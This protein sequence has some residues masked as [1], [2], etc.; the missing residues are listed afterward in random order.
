MNDIEAYFLFSCEKGLKKRGKNGIKEYEERLKYETTIIRNMGYCGYF[1]VV[2]DM[3]DWALSQ[4]IPIGPGRGSAAGALVSYVLYIT[5]LDPIKYKLIFE[6]FL[7]PSRISMPDID[8]DLDE[9]RREEV[10]DYLKNKYGKDN[11]AHIGT[12]GKMKAKAAIRDVCRTLGFDYNVGDKLSRLTLD[13]IAGKSQPLIECYD[14]VPELKN[15]RYGED[16]PEKTILSWAEKIEDKEKSFGTHA[17]FAYSSQ[18][19]TTFGPKSIG[20]LCGETVEILTSRGLQKAKISY[21]G[22]KEIVDLLFTSCKSSHRYQKISLTPDHKIYTNNGWIETEKSINQQLGYIKW[23]DKHSFISLFAGWIWNDGCW[24]ESQ[25]REY[26]YFTPGDD[27][28]AKEYFL[29]ALCSQKFLNRLDKHVVKKAFIDQ[30][31]EKFGENFKCKLKDKDVPIFHNLSDK[32]GWLCGFISANGSIQRGE[33]RLKICSFK[34]LSFIKNEIESLGIF[35]SSIK[36]RK[37]QIVYIDNRKIINN[38]SYEICLSVSSSFFFLSLIG[39]IQKRKED[40]FKQHQVFYLRNCRIE[41][42]YDFSVLN[43]DPKNQNGYVNGLLVHNSGILISPTPIKEIVPLYP[44]LNG[45]A[46]TQY[47]MNIVDQVGLTKFDLLGLRAL[48][49]IDKCINLIYQRKNIRLNSLELPVDDKKTFKTLQR[50]D[51]VGLFQLESSGMRDLVVQIRP[52]KLED[53][54]VLVA[55]YRPGPLSSEGFKHYLE[56]RKGESSPHYLI[57]ELE[58]I[59]KDTDGFMIYQEQVLEICKQLAGYS[60]AEADLMRKAI[61]KKLDKEMNDQEKKFKEGLYNSNISEHAANQLWNDIKAFSDYSFNRAHAICYGFIAYQ[62]AYLK[63]HYPLEFILSCLITDSNEVDKVIQFISYCKEYNINILGPDI[64]KSEYEFSID[65][66]NNIRFGLSAIK[67]MGKPLLEVITERNKCGAFKDIIDFCNRVDLSKINKKKLESLVF[68]G[69]FDEISVNRAASILAIESVINHKDEIKRYET[70]LETYN[71]KLE[72]YNKRLKDIELWDQ[73]KEEN[74]KRKIKRPGIIKTPEKPEEPIKPNIQQIKE[75][76]V[77]DM[78]KKEKELLGY[79]VSQ[80][81]L[82]FVKEKTD[83][84]IKSIKECVNNFIMKSGT[85]LSIIAIPSLIKEITTKTSKQKMAYANL[86][87]KT[88]TIQSIIFPRALAENG[89]Y[90]NIS[91]PAEYYGEIEITDGEIDKI[92][93]FKVSKVVPLKSII[94]ENKEIDFC[95]TS[96]K[97]IEVANYLFKEKGNT[98]IN[99]SYLTK[100]NNK[101]TFGKFSSSRNREEVLSYKK[102]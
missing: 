68:A 91:V 56:V 69:A 92:I 37:S 25:Q 4:R 46:T 8:L 71:K 60:L 55:I 49:T 22:K 84:N 74:K 81:P 3:L 7:N 61:G 33:I 100:G 10:I 99:F 32:I 40:R 83:H 48:T 39:I 13:P 26:C 6:R 72:T 79:F 57:P 41:D 87:D 30:V 77:M 96:D 14:K 9:I 54:G 53:I 11:V 102:A 18:L 31:I 15:L 36:K 21:A 90:I 58:P 67:N 101:I 78:L 73:N 59:L 1:L 47:D 5:H 86:E 65:K 82:D 64:N 89:Q 2:S 35:V 62:M 24:I 16:C 63:T 80:H 52:T 27:D 38:G 29:P 94:L 34:L 45:K 76:D 12:F 28:E 50:G 85:K 44:G 88:G 93:K 70:R 75:L 98:K 19:L 51:T 20:S 95:L 17:C 23:R 42:T 66:D 97:L 43:N